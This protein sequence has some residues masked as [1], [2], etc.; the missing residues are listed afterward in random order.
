MT[1]HPKLDDLLAL[2]VADRLALVEALWEP[3]ARTPE[4]VPAPDWH[5]DVLDERL[6]ADDAAPDAGEIWAEV[7]QHVERGR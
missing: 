4:Q 2:P 6:A 3:L 5:R 7:R 1:Q